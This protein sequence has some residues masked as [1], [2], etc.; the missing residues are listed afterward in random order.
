MQRIKLI[1]FDYN[2]TLVDD[3]RYHVDAYEKIFLE[4]GIK[5]DK[6]WLYKN[7]GLSTSEKINYFL[8]LN[9]YTEDSKEI[10]KRKSDVYN[11]L[12]QG[13]N[14]LYPE[15]LKSLQR[16]SSKYCLALYT[17]SAR[18]QIENSLPKEVKELL[19][20]IIAQEDAIKPKPEPDTLL[21]IADKLKFDISEC[22]Y[23]GDADTDMMAAK[24]AGML[25]IGV[26]HQKSNK[27]ELIDAGA[28][29][30]FPDLEIMTDYFLK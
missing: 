16:L 12:V 30:V 3:F 5:I 4:I 18:C 25:P 23:V 7:S 10:L 20:L 28:E 29:H 24:N 22:V 9:K 21:M 27:S 15:A 1:I 11:K 2:E 6:K 8:E 13:K 26:T 17:G 19:K 14:I